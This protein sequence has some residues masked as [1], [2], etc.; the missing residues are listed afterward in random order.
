MSSSAQKP[1]NKRLIGVLLGLAVAMFGFGFALVPLYNIFCE[2]T[3]I[4]GRVID[5]DQTAA[6]Q[7][8][9]VDTSRTIT[10]QFDSSIERGLPW[11]FA[12]N[13][14]FLKVHP[15][16]MMETSYRASSHDDDATTGHAAYS[17]A[18][19][20]AG[21]YFTKTECFCFYPADITGG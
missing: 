3:G 16:E 19:G 5:V 11:D 12:P 4:N 8:N 2:I 21:L 18:P 6:V 14:K 13:E 7:A 20:R 1:V 15:G 17:V 9:V 10:I